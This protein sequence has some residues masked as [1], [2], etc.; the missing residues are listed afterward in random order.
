M[1]RVFAIVM[2][3]TLPAAGQTAG[4]LLQK[5]I[6]AQ[7]TVGDFEGAMKI[8]RQISGSAGVTRPY[9][10]QAEYRRAECLAG[11]GAKADAAMAFRRFLD[12]YPEQKELV[13]KARESMRGLAAFMPTEYHDAGTGF[14]FVAP[15]GEWWAFRS[16]RF[17]NG[18]VDIVFD[19]SGPW[20][21]AGMFVYSR[22]MAAGDIARHLQERLATWAA[23]QDN[24]WVRRVRP[25]TVSL[26][27]VGRFQVLS[28]VADIGNSGKAMYFVAWVASQQTEVCIELNTNDQYL[29]GVRRDFAAIIET[30]KMP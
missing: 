24:G 27:P 18:S 11:K 16:K 5:G 23:W 25:E 29:D 21:R 14:S 10:A 17:D 3:A 9:V 26:R 22:K 6:Y 7:E 8:Y 28:C 30:V 1:L 4:E 15:H 20:G 13:A 12:D 19:Q 2:I